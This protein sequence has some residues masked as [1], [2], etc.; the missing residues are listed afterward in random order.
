MWP[1]TIKNK[2]NRLI[3]S[4][5]VAWSLSLQNSSAV[6]AWLSFGNIGT[7]WKSTA[8]K[9]GCVSHM[10]SSLPYSQLNSIIVADE[11]KSGCPANLR[12]H[13]ALDNGGKFAQVGPSH[14]IESIPNDTGKLPPTKCYNTFMTFP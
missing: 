6:P 12:L 7:S 1:V 11:F 13:P 8:W 3:T 5:A 14:R 4:L 10:Q 9:R 2:S